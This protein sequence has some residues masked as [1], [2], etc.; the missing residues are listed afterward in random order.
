MTLEFIPMSQIPVSDWLELLNH[1]LVKRHMPLAT[2][3]FTPSG[4]AA[5]I[6][7]GKTT[8]TDRK[9]SCTTVS[10]SAGAAF[11]PTGTTP[12]W[13]WCCTRNTGVWASRSSKPCCVRA[14]RRF[15]FAAS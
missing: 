11:N 9:P 7:C 2:E 15:S 14:S 10:S 6:A 4:C 12:T 5:W 1:P 13:D 3:D 8:V